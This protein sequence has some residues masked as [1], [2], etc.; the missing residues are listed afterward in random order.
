MWLP[1]NPKHWL[2]NVTSTLPHFRVESCVI[3]IYLSNRRKIQGAG[4]VKLFI[5]G[6]GRHLSHMQEEWVG[7]AYCLSRHVQP[8]DKV[9]L[10]LHEL[11]LGDNKKKKCFPISGWLKMNCFQR[12]ATLVFVSMP[13]IQ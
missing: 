10:L 9:S 7:C 8:Y 6:G 2:E 11:Y 4:L 12:Y 13:I 1:L 3:G 5:M